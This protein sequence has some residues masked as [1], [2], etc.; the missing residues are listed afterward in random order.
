MPKRDI[1]LTTPQSQKYIKVNPPTE[2]GQKSFHGF[3]WMLL[4]SFGTKI[5][6]LVSQ[7]VLAWALMP[8]DFGLVAL[9]Y[10]VTAFTAVLQRN[11]L[12]EILIQ[13]S[14][15]FANYANSAF[16]LSLLIGLIVTVLTLLAA[17][18]AAKIYKEPD[19]VKILT[20]LACG[21][22]MLSLQSVPGAKLQAEL[23]FREISLINL[24]EG[25]TTATL[26]VIFA[27]SGFK[28]YS[29]VLPIPLVHFASLLV[30][31]H[32]S[33]FRPEWN[34]SWPIGCDLIG[35]S[36]L[37][38]ITGLLYAFN[39]Q[40]ANIVLGL[41]HGSAVVG[42]FFF[43]YNLCIQ[44]N[45]L[46]TNNLYSILLP[47]FS[48]IQENVIRQTQAF[49]RVS[50]LVNLIGMFIC[51]LLAAIAEPLVRVLYGAKWMTAIPSIQILSLGMTFGISFA[52][53]VNLMLAQGLF[54]KLL[55][56]NL[57]RSCGF[58]TIVAI[59]AQIGGSLSVSVATAITTLLFGPII[60]YIS[61]RPGGYGLLE[62]VKSQATP[63]LIGASSCGAAVLLCS[64]IPFP[65]GSIWLWIQVLA[66][67]SIST[68][69]W[70]PL[71]WFFQRDAWLECSALVSRSYSNYNRRTLSV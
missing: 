22:I 27:L 34:F 51:F 54:K 9:A 55:W 56:F 52:L 45:S 69:I 2:L 17:P 71:C 42:V 43:A 58:I 6:T 66:T 1:R 32:K 49:I 5:F 57:F 61:I 37:L 47:A 28:A 67:G 53:S 60:T 13:R 31:L 46:L 24:L 70:I 63:F 33:G 14:N 25:V 68:L 19:L 36:S 21:Q 38:L 18:F 44:I 12:R 11:G 23:R 4:S 40:G 7:L 41:F 39:M 48:N 59:A 20:I 3:A 26:T 10:S 65:Q 16:W 64:I 15:S 8:T 35:S 62:V 50:R 29:I 30:Q